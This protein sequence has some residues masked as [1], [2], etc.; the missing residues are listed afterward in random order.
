MLR[1]N[2]PVDP[3]PPIVEPADL[4][5]LS[6]LSRHLSGGDRMPPGLR[7]FR[8]RSRNKVSTSID[9]SYAASASYLAQVAGSR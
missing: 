5:V 9:R 1:A 8:Y 3:F 4:G 6:G 7:Q 2:P